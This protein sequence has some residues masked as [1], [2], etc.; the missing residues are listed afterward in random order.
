MRGIL[1]LAAW[2]AARSGVVGLVAIALSVV[3]VAHLSSYS[4]QFKS[5]M[6]DIGGEMTPLL[7]KG[8]LVVAP[9]PT[10]RRSP[11]ITSPPGSSTRPRPGRVKDPSYMDWV[12]ALKRLQAAQPARTLDPAGC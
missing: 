9:N 4:P 1:L 10:R 11:G 5:D 7:H 3:F 12:D 2:G 6:R 8:D